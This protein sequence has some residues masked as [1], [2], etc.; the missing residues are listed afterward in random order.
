MSRITAKNLEIRKFENWIDWNPDLANF[1]NETGPDQNRPD[2]GPD[3]ISGRLLTATYNGQT[4]NQ[5]D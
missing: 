4:L 3:Q 1:R 5:K 2:P